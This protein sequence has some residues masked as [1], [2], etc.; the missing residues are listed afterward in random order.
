M[1]SFV[2]LYIVSL[3]LLCTEEKGQVTASLSDE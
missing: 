1:I 2:I 3:Q